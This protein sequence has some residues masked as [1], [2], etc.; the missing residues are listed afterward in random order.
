MLQSTKEHPGGRHGVIFQ[1]NNAQPQT[2]NMTKAAI[3][4][5]EWE[6]LPHPPYIPDLAPSDYH[7]FRSLSPQQSARSFLQH[8]RSA[9]KLAR[10]II[11]GQTGR[12]LQAWD[13]KSTRTLGVSRE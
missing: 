9:P 12:F 10:Q 3:Q 7:F 8:Q 2:A 11:H 4:E 5:L 1:H 13:Q 6:I